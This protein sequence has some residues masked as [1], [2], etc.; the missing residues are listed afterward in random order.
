MPKTLY[1]VD[2]I[3][4]TDTLYEDVITQI[5]PEDE[6]D[7]MLTNTKFLRITILRLIK[8]FI[9]HEGTIFIKEFSDKP[10]MI[11]D[12]P[13]KFDFGIDEIETDLVIVKQAFNLATVN[14]ENA[15]IPE[16]YA[17]VLEALDTNNVFK[18]T[19]DDYLDDLFLYYSGEDVYSPRVQKILIEDAV[20]VLEKWENIEDTVMKEMIKAYNYNYGINQYDRF[21]FWQEPLDI[22][23]KKYW[24]KFSFVLTINDYDLYDETKAKYLDVIADKYFNKGYFDEIV[25]KMN[26]FYWH[27]DF[28]KIVDWSAA[29]LR[30]TLVSYRFKT[31]FS[32]DTQ[33]RYF[34]DEEAALYGDIQRKNSVQE[35]LDM[36]EYRMPVFLEKILTNPQ[37]YGFELEGGYFGKE[38]DIPDLTLD[39]DEFERYKDIV[40]KIL[41]LSPFANPNDNFVKV[42]RDP[43]KR[44]FICVKRD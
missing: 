38:G 40:C 18:Q 7:T 5:Y 36:F 11:Y 34:D 12:D 24:E 44:V 3:D 17:L 1:Y 13:E 41:T 14:A 43:Q 29:N 30:S 10:V 22:I 21:T 4:N 23:S 16:K 6:W 37:T 25:I 2:T 19:W 15:K 39:S 35:E 28:Q 9:D 42:F 8:D 20:Q 26:Y 32:N 31:V 27:D 33:N